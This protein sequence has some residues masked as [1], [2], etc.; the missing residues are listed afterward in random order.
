MCSF[1]S[2][3]FLN[4]GLS[5]F[6]AHQINDQ[7]RYYFFVNQ[8]GN[9]NGKSSFVSMVALKFCLYFNND[10]WLSSMSEMTAILFLLIFTKFY[11]VGERIAYSVGANFTPHVITVN[12]GEV[13]AG[14][15]MF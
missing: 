5:F 2:L 4:C 6:Q 10:P 11:V 7:L 15:Y 8:F 1:H 14:K 12:A 3:D 9:E 13:C